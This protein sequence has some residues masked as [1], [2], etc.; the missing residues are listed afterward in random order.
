M[1]PWLSVI[2]VALSYLC[3]MGVY[4]YFIIPLGATYYRNALVSFLYYLSASIL[5]LKFFGASYIEAYT[6]MRQGA[7]IALAALTLALLI[8][9]QILK[10]FSSYPRISREY[11][12]IA[13]LSFRYPFVLAKTGEIMFQQICV[14]LLVFALADIYTSISV[15]AVS[16]A[17]VFGAMHAP[18]FLVLRARFAVAFTLAAFASGFVIPPLVLLV[19]GGVMYSFVLHWSFYIALAYFI[20]LNNGRFFLPV[21]RQA[22]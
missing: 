14:V 1:D 16:Y 3:G 2:I 8:T 10:R 4:N 20:Y 19:E 6:G 7:Q 11:P 12:R 15:I 21:P 9:P 22:T 13:T 5:L 18:L 17:L